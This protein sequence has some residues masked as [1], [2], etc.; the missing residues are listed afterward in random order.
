MIGPDGPPTTA[1]TRFGAVLAAP[2]VGVLVLGPQ[3]DIL[4]SSASV[5]AFLGQHA[6]ALSGR[7]VLDLDLVMVAADGSPA[8]SPAGPLAE[9]LRTGQPLE[10]EILGIWCDAAQAYTWL[11]LNAA[12]QVDAAGRLVQVV[13]AFWDIT[14]LARTEEHLRLSEQVLQYVGTLVLIANGQGQIVYATPSVQT[15]LGYAPAELLGDGWWALSRADPADREQ[16]KAYVA[17]C[18]RGERPVSPAP[19]ERLVQSRTGAPRWILWQD[20]KG[21]GDLMIG[22]GHDITARKQAEAALRHSEERFAKAFFASPYTITITR[23]R[24]GQLLDVNESWERATGYSRDEVLSG[25][26]DVRNLVVDSAALARLPALLGTQGAA[27]DLEIAYQRRS[28]E[29]R[30]AV[31]SMERIELDGEACLLTLGRD[32]TEQKRTLVALNASEGQFRAV[33][34]GALDAM[35][36]LDAAGRFVQVNPAAC[37]L[38]GATPA[39]LLARPIADFVDGEYRE[40][41]DTAWQRLDAQGEFRGELRIRQVAGGAREVEITATAHFQ[42]GR[43]LV[44]LRD[45]TERKQVEAALARQTATLQAQA[46]F[47]DLAYDAILVEDLHHTILFWNHGAEEL[48]GWTKQEAIGQPS[49]VLLQTS[50]PQPLAETLDVLQQTGR[51]EGELVHTTRAGQQIIVASRWALQRDA[52]AQSPAILQINTDITKRKQAEAEI[53]D[54]LEAQRTANAQLRRLSK[55]KSDFVAIVSH[56]FRTPLTVIQ[57]LSSLMHDEPFSLEQMKEYAQDINN[58]ARRLSRLITDM[59]DLDRMEAGKMSLHREP[60]DLNGIIVAVAALIRP[61][62]PH[63]PLILELHPLLP[64]LSGDRDKLTQVVTNLLNNAVKYS[65]AGGAICIRSQAEGHTVHVQV[66]DQGVG[67][68]PDALGT[69]FER[70]ARVESAAG[71]HIQGTGLGLPIVRQIIEMHGGT[72]WVESTLGAGSTFHFTLPGASDTASP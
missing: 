11:L 14:E 30:Q 61:N 1:A 71:R 18:A 70:Y 28:G 35:L 31:V 17:Q 63:H 32:V 55:V 9:V 60:L 20:A 39:A 69:I 50:F 46:Q 6:T 51:W 72:V 48:Y 65:P 43:H 58:E 3:G 21:P 33:F 25:A 54:A 52:Q 49:Y 10:H 34:D 26:L 56:E 59:L 44:V 67:I 53:A 47:L 4:H 2:R 8:P 12:P 7:R 15:V 16:E 36:I 24:D 64:V 42:P 22:A 38:Y 45:I 62:A 66:A 29:I 27:H 19:Y 5:A 40:A 41:L 13:C 68:P 23:L 57:G 37:A